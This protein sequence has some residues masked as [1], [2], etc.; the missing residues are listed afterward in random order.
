M[1]QADRFVIGPNRLAGEGDHLIALDLQEQHLAQEEGTPVT[2]LHL[3]FDD[4]ALQPAKEAA[5]DVP[6]RRGYRFLEL[7]EWLTCAALCEPGSSEVRWYAPRKG[8]ATGVERILTARGWDLSQAKQGKMLE[9]A[10]SPPPAGESPTPASFEATLADHRLRFAAD[11]GVFSGGRVDDGTQLLF[12]AAMEGDPVDLLVDIG[13]GYG[14]LGIGLVVAGHASRVIATEVDSVALL[15]AQ[16]NARTADIEL[17]AHLGDDPSTVRESALT[18]CNFPTHARREDSDRLLRGLCQRARSGRVLTVVHA[19]LE[20]RFVQRFADEGV[21]A[22]VVR[23]A[24][25]A[26]LSLTPVQSL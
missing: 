22:S 8:G 19:S 9:L 13:T 24:T 3:L 1:I 2:P 18:V 7:L 26:V 10:G 12:D 11:W 15:L 16:R 14:P 25:H 5:I 6:G 4:L 21:R 23:R 20:S 17:W